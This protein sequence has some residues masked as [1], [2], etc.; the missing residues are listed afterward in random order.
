[1]SDEESGFRYEG[2]VD[3]NGK[4]HGRGTMHMGDGVVFTG[5]LDI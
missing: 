4:P 3:D 2:N 5:L 1:M